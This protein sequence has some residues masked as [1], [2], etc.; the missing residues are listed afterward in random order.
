MATPTPVRVYAGTQE[1]SFIL[2][3]RRMGSIA[4]MTLE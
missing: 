3:L 4:R 2:A 1:G